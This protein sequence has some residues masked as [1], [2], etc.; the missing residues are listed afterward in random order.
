MMGRRWGCTW[1]CSARA[2]TTGEIYLPPRSAV[3]SRLW[4]LLR[5]WPR[6]LSQLPGTAPLWGKHAALEPVRIQ[7]RIKIT[8][9]ETKR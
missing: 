1:K 9:K 6:T 5:D 4:S 7:G 2:A 8:A 3:P